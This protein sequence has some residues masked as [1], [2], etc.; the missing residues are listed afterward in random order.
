MIVFY[1]WGLWLNEKGGPNS[2]LIK[3]KLLYAFLEKIKWEV[4]N[5]L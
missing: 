4:R 5:K 3:E 2:E 1:F